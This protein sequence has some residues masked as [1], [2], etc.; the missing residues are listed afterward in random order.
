MSRV[1][2][3]SPGAD[4]VA[5]SDRGGRYASERYRRLLGGY[6]IVCSMSRRADCW[7][8]APMESFFA[9]LRKELTRG[10][11]IATR[12]EARASIFEYID[13]IYK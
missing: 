13:F 11:M 6:G 12:A 10:E 2:R 4:L 8:D 9:P 3:G 1:P 7:D 5:H